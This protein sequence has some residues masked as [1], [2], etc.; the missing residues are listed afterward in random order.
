MAEIAPDPVSPVFQTARIP[1]KVMI[2]NI[3]L[4]ESLCGFV[5]VCPISDDR[6]YTSIHLYKDTGK[7]SCAAHL[8][9]QKLVMVLSSETEF[10]SEEPAI[11]IGPKDGGSPINMA[12]SCNP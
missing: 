10:H 9:K 8:W 12:T 5:Q 6:Q 1:A 7:F 2:T 4:I 11:G 3:G